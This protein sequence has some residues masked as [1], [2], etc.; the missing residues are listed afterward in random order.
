MLR[1]GQLSYQH[2]YVS[3]ADYAEGLYEQ[4]LHYFMD[5][6]SFLQL[7]FV[8]LGLAVYQVLLRLLEG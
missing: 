6:N 2:L 8:H 4:A 7:G 1:V 5:R 3:V